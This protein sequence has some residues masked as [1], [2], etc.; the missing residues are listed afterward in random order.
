MS[1]AQ[2]R[3]R[4]PHSLDSQS[5]RLQLV[6]VLQILSAALPSTRMQKRANG[7]CA[8]GSPVPYRTPNIGPNQMDIDR[9]LPFINCK[10]SE[11]SSP[12]IEGQT[13]LCD[14]PTL[15]ETELPVECP[16]EGPQRPID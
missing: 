7:G 14:A 6:H 11:P 4:K 8:K 3:H 5:G 13:D 1:R 9:G 16:P 12:L 2:M 10:S 15:F